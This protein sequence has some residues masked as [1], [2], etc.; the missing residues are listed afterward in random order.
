MAI[1]VTISE[2]LHQDVMDIRSGSE[3][4]EDVI[5]RLL[6]SYGNVEFEDFS[7]EKAAYYNERYEKFINGDREGTH[8]VDIDALI[9]ELK[10]K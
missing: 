4:F 2:D 10:H 7:D 6:V 5:E 9:C 3:N 1:T 8:E